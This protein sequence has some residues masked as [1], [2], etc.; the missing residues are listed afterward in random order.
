M[1]IFGR[2]IILF[3]AKGSE[4]Q[5]SLRVCEQK[6]KGADRNSKGS[7]EQRTWV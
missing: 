3:S 7:Q 6:E 5:R 1:A 2:E 4:S